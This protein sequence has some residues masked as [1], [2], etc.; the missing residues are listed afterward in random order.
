MRA[1]L[2]TNM[3][4]S[5]IQNGIQ[6]A[7]CLAEMFVAYS[8]G[9][10]IGY[11]LP[12]HPRFKAMNMLFDWAINHKTMV[13]VNGGNSKNLHDIY[14]SF[15]HMCSELE[16]PYMMFSED[17]DSLNRATTCVGVIVPEK[18]YMYN[19]FEQKRNRP[20]VGP[21][22]DVLVLNPYKLNTIEKTFADIIA[23]APLAR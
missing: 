4:L 9:D 22:A 1:Y 12:T 11:T 7:H 3:Y 23:S 16:Y 6:S 5:S 15:N 10:D 21:I 18:I 8:R 17:L 13:V 19:E 2:F 14:L 20:S